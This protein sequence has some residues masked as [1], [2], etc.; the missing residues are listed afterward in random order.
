LIAPTPPNA[1]DPG[2]EDSARVL[3][4]PPLLLVICIGVGL[5]AWRSLPW[6]TLSG[7][8][9]IP[10]A[11]ICG[12]AGL[13]ADRWAQRSLRQAHTA[14]H[15][16]HATTAVVDTGPF[17]YSR[18]PIYLAQGCFL[19]CVGF[20]TRGTAF[21]LALLPWYLVMRL[22]VIAREERYLAGKFGADYLSYVGRVRRWL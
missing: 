20:M 11:L 5:L 14:V 21:F 17:K 15:P 2:R 6:P 12:I 8:F 1:S 18:N 22:G 4:F 16:A 10:M 19:A 9:A 7:V 3:I 13:V